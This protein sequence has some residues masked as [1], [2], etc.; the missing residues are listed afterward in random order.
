MGRTARALALA[1]TL[2]V[3]AC[4]G[5]GGGGAPPSQPGGDPT[6]PEAASFAAVPVGTASAVSVEGTPTQ[7]NLHVKLQVTGVTNTI[8]LG[9][10]GD[11]AV[12][13]DVQGGAEG[14]NLDLAFLLRGDLPPGR[15]DTELLLY[16]CFDEACDHEIP[17]SPVILPLAYEVKP[18]IQV[19]SQVTLARAGREPAPSVSL[20]V[21]VPPEAGALDVQITNSRPG[22]A[23]AVS[24]DGSLHVQTAQVQAGTYTTTATLRS[25]SDPRYTR[26]VA[27][28]YTVTAP[29]GGE[30]TLSVDPAFV[31]LAVQQGA[32][33]VQ[34]LTVT[35]PTWTSAFDPPQITNDPQGML[36][37]VDLGN[38]R[39]EV[40]IDGVGKAVGSYSP[41]VVFSAGDGLRVGVAINTYVSASFYLDGMPAFMLTT[42]STPADLHGS[43]LVK[44]FDGSMPRWT[45]VS[46]SPLLLLG[47]TT[48]VANVDPLD[49]VLDAAAL[50]MPDWGLG[51]EVQVSIDTPGT[52]VQSFYYNVDN[53]IA[54]L[55][56]AYPATIVGAGGRIYLQGAL[57]Y[58]RADPLHPDRMQV[59]GANRDSARIVADTRLA[60]D[61]SLLEMDVSAA[62]AGQPIAIGIDSALLPTQ[63]QV[64]VKAPLRPAQSAYATLPY[65]ERRPGQYAPGLDAY[66]F[67]GTDTVYRW[68]FDGSTWTLVQATLAGVVDVAP[69]PDESA[70]YAVTTARLH[71]L[72]RT[73]LASQLDS[74]LSNWGGYDL[75]FDGTAPVGTHALAFAA[76]GR[77][78]ASLTNLAF[79]YGHGASWICRTAYTRIVPELADGAGICDPGYRLFSD[80]DA[81]GAALVRS[82]SGSVVLDVRPTGART[83]YNPRNADWTTLS[84]I[85]AGLKIVSV[86]DDAGRAVRSDGTLVDIDGV[87]LGNLGGA[88]PFTHVTGGYAIGSNGRYGYVYGYRVSGTG[89]GQRAADATLWVIDLA[90]VAPTP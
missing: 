61:V 18:N 48:G 81:A 29:P 51:L 56:R 52:S 62:V 12:L 42:S 67:A 33:S 10:Y 71:R 30:Q 69:A 68:A 72:D 21:V 65:A 9:V 53:G 83:A 1:C 50:S 4:G 66:Y 37:L 64:A 31:S 58:S 14:D 19:Q 57:G 88:L 80:V 59:N 34:T 22:G 79:P 89:T 17:G 55:Q 73:T 15:H 47:R 7:T 28:D 44:T 13:L 87:P 82:T 5:G 27:V 6:P 85:G 86:S 45:A 25:L 63:L 70:V 39:Y 90:T 32:R 49:V 36:T 75:R 35:R 76:D 54:T 78:L 38:D 77:A 40:T 23:I 46:K 84:A 3:A 41:Q 26:T 43:N 20:P 16:A 24:Y 74:A 8:Y 2:L 11:P 60:G